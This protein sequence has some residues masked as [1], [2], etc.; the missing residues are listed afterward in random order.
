MLR[1]IQSFAHRIRA[2][3]YE[4]RSCSIGLAGQMRQATKNRMAE[5]IMNDQRLTTRL[6]DV[7]N[8]LSHEEDI[9]DFSKLNVSTIEDLWQSCMVLV[10]MPKSTSTNRAQTT[11]KLHH[12]GRK[13]SD[14]IGN[15]SVGTYIVAR[16]RQF[17]GERII[18]R[19]DELL[20]QPQPIEE[21]GQFINDRHKVVK[22]R[23]CLLP[24]GN[25]Q[26]GVTHVLV[27]LAWREF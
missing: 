6:I 21:S 1:F 25:R 23:S 16:T 27:G 15:A 14:V 24:F 18:Q 19:I 2:A 11:L 4:V 12:I 10:P 3:P 20:D 26:E 8:R 9:P 22:Y 7:W 17:A 13:V 5:S